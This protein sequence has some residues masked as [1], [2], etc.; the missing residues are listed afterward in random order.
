V[1]VSEE[2]MIKILQTVTPGTAVT[3]Y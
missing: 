2:D 3:I 1:A